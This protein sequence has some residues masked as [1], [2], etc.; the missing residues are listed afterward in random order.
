M[1]MQDNYNTGPVT[2]LIINMILIC[3][4]IY[5]SFA[6][7]YII[8]ISLE[9]LIF[10]LKKHADEDSIYVEYDYSCNIISM[11]LIP[12]VNEMEASLTAISTFFTWGLNVRLIKWS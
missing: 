9:G 6:L 4:F 10:F 2:I 1:K 8:Y 12:V 5:V 11:Q 3:M 7:I